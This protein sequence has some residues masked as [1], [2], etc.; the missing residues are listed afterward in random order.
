[1]VLKHMRLNFL[2]LV[3]KVWAFAQA[4]GSDEACGLRR[5]LTSWVFPELCA[6]M[7]KLDDG[8]ELHNQ[9]K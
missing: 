7:N 6:Q 9:F 2:D 3:G 5:A 8:C 4:S 1:M